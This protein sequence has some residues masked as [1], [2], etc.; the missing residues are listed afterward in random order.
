MTINVSQFYR[1]RKR[2]EILEKKV[3]PYLLQ[4]KNHLK[5]WSAAC[6]TGEEPYTLAMIINHFL[7][8]QN[9]EIMATDL[10]GQALEKARQGVY[11][12]RSLNEVPEEIKRKYF[13]K[14]GSSYKVNDDIRNCVTFKKHNLLADPFIP[15]CDLIVCRNVL[16][17]FTEA[18]KHY[19]YENFSRSLEGGGIFFVGSAEQI[20]S[21]QRYQLAVFDAF[22]YKRMCKSLM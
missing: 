5:V 20:F 13:V 8:L 7:P 16:I 3:L 21:P 4:N 2:F 15:S 18:A 1:N 19:I 10:D 9:I 11:P 14:T 12:E 22:F 17:Y 6:S